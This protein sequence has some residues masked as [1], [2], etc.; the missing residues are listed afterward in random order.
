MRWCY[1]ELNLLGDPALTFYPEN[2]SSPD[3]PERPSGPE[4]GYSGSYYYFAIGTSD[5]NGDDV[6]YY[7]NWGDMTNTGWFGPYESGPGRAVLVSHTWNEGG[8]HEIKVKAADIH[9]FIRIAKSELKIVN[10]TF[11]IGKVCSILANPG[12]LD[13]TNVHWSIQVTGG[14]LKNV[15][16]STGDTISELDA[17]DEITFNTDGLIVGLGKVEIVVTANADTVD[18]VTQKISAFM[19]GPFMVR[20]YT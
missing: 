1:Y 8:D 16:K 10:I 15:D 5:P 13:A 4:F 18:R 12:D 9:G 14:L 7:V 11:K 6:Y 3:K 19:I 2:N 20:L 17:G